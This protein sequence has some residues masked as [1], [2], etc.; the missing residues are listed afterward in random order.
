[1]TKDMTILAIDTSQKSCSVALCRGDALIGQQSEML[2]R[3]HAERLL[4]M[5][6]EVLTASNVAYT[7]LDRLAVVTGPGAYTGVRIGV[8]AARGL[9]LADKIPCLGFTALQVAMTQVGVPDGII[10]STAAGRGD[11]VFAQTFTKQN[12][13]ITGYTA[14]CSMTLDEARSCGVDH[15]I[16]SGRVQL[17]LDDEM[18]Q[19]HMPNCHHLALLAS[20]AD[21]DDH[22]AEPT[23][24]RAADAAPAK[25]IFEVMD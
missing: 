14:A 11:T 18:S 1:M 25:V 19:G 17:G 12:G 8:A 3:G 13:E 10:L 2:G 7:E 16:G 6:D 9:A 15:I 20:R 4:P 24:F 23:Y 21:P 5:I 22:P